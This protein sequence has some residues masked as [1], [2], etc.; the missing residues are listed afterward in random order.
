M[1]YPNSTIKKSGYCTCG[2]L[3][4]LLDIEK[5]TDEKTHKDTLLE[6]ASILDELIFY[7]KHT[8]SE[9]QKPHLRLVEGH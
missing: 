8:A 2:N 5:L 1:K 9:Q 3:N 6:I 4:L 7:Y